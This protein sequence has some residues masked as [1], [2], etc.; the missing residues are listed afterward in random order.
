MIYCKNCNAV[1]SDNSDNNYIYDNE[2]YCDE[3]CVNEYLTKFARE[4]AF[5]S[6]DAFHYA[7]E[8]KIKANNLKANIPDMNLNK[9]KKELRR[10]IDEI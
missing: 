5:L 9:I 10:L 4:L 2:E 7:N 6:I 8:M 3:D 1:I